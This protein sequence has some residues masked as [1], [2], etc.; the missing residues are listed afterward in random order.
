MEGEESA[1]TRG[2]AIISWSGGDHCVQNGTQV[3]RLYIT[4]VRTRDV[5]PSVV[6]NAE[7]AAAPPSTF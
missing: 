5:G 6:R 2:V 1:P 7:I 3:N 4:L